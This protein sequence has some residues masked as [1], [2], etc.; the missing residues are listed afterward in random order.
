MRLPM[1]AILAGLA[2]SPA[3]AGDVPASDSH[4]IATAVMQADARAL[5]VVG[6]SDTAARHAGRAGYYRTLGDLAQ[7]TRW[8]R[9]CIANPQVVAEPGQQ[10]MY[11]CRS[12]L[13][14]N[15]LLAGDIGG[16]AVEMEQVRVLYREHVAPSLRPGGELAAVARPRF[17]A[18]TGWPRQWTLHATAAPGTRVPVADGPGVPVVRCRIRGGRDGKARDV[19][20]DF[21]IDTG[22][23]HS[24]VSRR[25]AQAMGLEVRDGF[26]VDA[27]DPARW[28]E[29]G[30]AT[31]VDLELGGIRFGDVAFSVPDAMEPALIGLDLLA[32]LGPLR[33]GAD[34]LEVLAELPPGC[35]AQ[36]AATSLPWGGQYALRLPMQIGRRK[37]LVL[38]DTGNDASLEMAGTDL[39][40]FPQAALVERSRL[41]IHGLQRVRHAEASAP[42]SFNGHAA[43]LPIRV[44]D[45][46]ARVFPVSWTAG[47]GL[48]T[49]Y[50]FHV[51][52]ATA[53]GCLLPR[54]AR[55]E[56]PP[57]AARGPRQARRT[58]AKSQAHATREAGA[59]DAGLPGI[60]RAAAPG[61]WWS[62][63]G[64]NRRPLACHASALPAE[65]WPHEHR[66]PGLCVPLEMWRP[67]GDSNPGRYR[68]RVVS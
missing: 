46:P 38:L 36:L 64:S 57:S 26:G 42:V 19:E 53:H 20:V 39:S 28:A 14:G 33:L 15:L 41:T 44:T 4:G 59:S 45:Q 11:L 21:I 5:A 61:S 43:E 66:P 54:A 25:A 6:K 24:H 8:A 18:F 17:E 16:W 29:I 37:E 40:A 58:R 67:H 68:E 47:Y 49:R 31:P 32:R 2:A 7:S 35:D 12:L 55:Q 60:R 10:L 27:S 34:E 48:R 52:V 23:P 13:A 62:Q 56:Q 22:A 51:D 50:D 9:A 30:L 65:L 3:S 63:P 1:L